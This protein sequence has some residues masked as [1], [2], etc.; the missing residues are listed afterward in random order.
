MTDAGEFRVKEKKLYFWFVV[1]EKDF[2]RV[3]RAGR[4]CVSRELKNNGMDMCCEKKIMIV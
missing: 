3:P 1:L 2:D 4:Q